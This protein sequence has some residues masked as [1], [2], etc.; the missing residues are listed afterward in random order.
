MSEQL[1]LS[2]PFAAI[3][4]EIETLFHDLLKYLVDPAGNYYKTDIQQ[5]LIDIEK[6]NVVAIASGHRYERKGYMYDPLLQS[7]VQGAGGQLSTWD[8]EKNTLTPVILRGITNRSEMAACKAA[9]RDFYYMDTGYFG[10]GKC[11]LYHR[12]TKND[13]QNFGPIIDRPM[14]RLSKTGFQ[15]KKFTRGSKILLAPPSQKLLNN[16][17]IDLKTWMEETIAEIK[18][19]SDREIVIRLKQNRSTRVNNNTIEM[20]LSKDIHCLVTF[21]SIAATESVLFGKPAITLG[22]NAAAS[23]CSKSISEIESP[24]IPTLEQVRQ[25]AAHLAYCQFT[26]LEM[27][28]GTAWRILNDH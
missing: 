6:H 7:F 14:D 9:C 15:P 19:H 16:Y 23:V 26:E 21:G 2:H 27:K 8:K 5:R 17:D 3:P 13:V 4:P 25:W 11:K 1:P 24:F 18:L 28:N 12:I 10:N 22:P 20:A